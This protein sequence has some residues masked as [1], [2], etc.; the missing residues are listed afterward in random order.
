MTL[1]QPALLT[2]G[3]THQSDLVRRFQ[4]SVTLG[5]EGIDFGGDLKVQQTSTASTSIV[6]GPGGAFVRGRASA[7]QG[8][9]YVS[10][11]DDHTVANAVP[12]LAT[13][14]HYLVV[15]RVLDPAYE[16]T[17]D[18]NLNMNRIEVLSTATGGTTLPAGVSGVVLARLEVPAN[19]TTVTSAMI[20][21]LRRMANPR[22]DRRLQP[23]F[24]PAVDALEAASGTREFWPDAAT[25]S[26]PVPTWA[27]LMNVVVTMTGVSSRV[28]STDGNTRVL[29][30]GQATQAVGFNHDWAGSTQRL[31]LPTGGA[32]GIT[33]AMRGTNQTLRTDAV[34]GNT[35]GTLEANAGTTVFF[36]F[37]FVEG[38]V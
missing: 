9:Y 34:R 19:T 27:S 13:V 8:T 5:N 24:I 23:V 29:L 22:R 26:V 12:S 25:I 20:V 30:G 15:L 31:V 33:S 14:Q 4:R 18:P 36:D 2:N 35:T 21:D 11:P 10:N 32:L 16:G 37:E 3:G 6:V 38:L 28:G 17:A 1:L 7:L